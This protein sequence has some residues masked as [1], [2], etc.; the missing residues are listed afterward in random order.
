MQS[1]HTASKLKS[2]LTKSKPNFFSAPEIKLLILSISFSIIGV[3]AVGRFSAAIGEQGAY[4]ERFV[5]YSNCLLCGNNPKCTM[6][7]AT[8]HFTLAIYAV[9][10]L[11][12]SLLF[13]VNIVFT[14]DASDMSRI[15]KV[16]C[17][18]CRKCKKT[19]SELVPQRDRINCVLCSCSQYI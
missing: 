6:E 11:A 16:L 15:S 1:L 5:E 9:S 4:A 8:D 13:A 2:D 3:I 12:Y 19:K 18:T 7:S 17:C 14:L 10:Q